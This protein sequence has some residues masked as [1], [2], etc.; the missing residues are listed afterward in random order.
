MQ[1]PPPPAPA[2][3]SLDSM[4]QAFEHSIT[5]E[6]DVWHADPVDVA[7]VHRKARAKFADL[8]DAVAGGKDTPKGAA[9]SSATRP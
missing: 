6:D 3:A 5:W 8:L 7:L 9:G 1:M 2:N 4:S